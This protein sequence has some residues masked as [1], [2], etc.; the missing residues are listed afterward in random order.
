MLADLKAAWQLR[1]P[2]I[3]PRRLVHVAVLILLAGV[4][5]GAGL[6]LLVPLLNSLGA[7]MPVMTGTASWFLALLPATLAGLLL[8][9][10]AVAVV[11]AVV[12][13]LQENAVASLRF[14]YAV[15]LKIRTYAA[16]ANASWSYLRRRRT[17]DFHAIFATEVDR[18]EHGVQLL[19][20]IPARLVIFLAHIAIAFAIAPAFSALAIALGLCLAWGLRR[21][22]VES[23][24]LGDVVSEAGTRV[25]REITEFLQAL[26][27]TKA[28]GAEAQHVG[29][30]ADAVQQAEGAGLANRRLLANTELILEIAT[31]VVLAALLWL[32][33]DWLGLPLAN[34]LV[35][36]FVFQ[37][38]MPM[39]QDI[40]NLAQ[41]FVHCSSAFQ[42]VAATIADCDAAADRIGQTPPERVSFD[43]ELRLEGVGFGYDAAGDVLRDIDLALPAGSLTVLSGVSGAG[44]STLLDLMGGLVVP[45]VGRI[46]IDGIELT[47]ALA[48]GWRRSVGYMAQEAFLFHDSIRANLA[49]ADPAASD[50]RM[51]DVLGLAGLAELLRALPDGLDTVVGDRGTNL[52]GGERQ[53]LA[54]A[55]TLLRE[56]RLILLDE[57]ASALDSQNEDRI[58]ETIAGLHGRTTIVVVTHRPAA[59]MGADRYLALV[60]GKLI[61]SP[62]ASESKSPL[63]S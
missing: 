29:A 12:A 24:R 5:D 44:K 16:I 57:P 26:K 42:I 56:P 36:I 58:L 34:L 32:A 62:S 46:L 51:L 4:S 10:L 50:E 47:A 25:S 3:G 20:E 31:A 43:R 19:L 54:L 55:R 33:V 9:F 6:V 15:D 17:A 35:L 7:P 1:G 41:E 30:F 52:S 49:W 23:R 37:R 11:R 63:A 13:R 40:Q 2:S 61:A 48:P 18:I 28:Y 53:R 38:L 59:I 45:T 8:L 39:F 27:L 14:D 60:D 22:L 21:R